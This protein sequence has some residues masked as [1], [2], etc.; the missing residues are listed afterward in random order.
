MEEKKTDVVC[1]TRTIRLEQLCYERAWW[2]RAFREVLATGV[3]LFA[4][5]Y[6]IRPEEY[7]TRS[8]MCHNCLRFRKTALKTQSPLFRRL[9]S[10]ANPVF[11]R[12]RGSLLTPEELEHAHRL[13]RLAED[14]A[15]SPSCSG[16][17]G[18]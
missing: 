8:P 7:K 16:G 2:F 10:A 6:R 3:R 4:F 13:A 17:A 18:N 12:V 14:R 1:K 11:N 5:A 15:Y 9:N